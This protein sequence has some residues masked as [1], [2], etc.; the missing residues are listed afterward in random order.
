[1]ARYPVTMAQY[2]RFVEEGGVSRCHMTGASPWT[3]PNHPV[4]DVTWYDALA[5]CGG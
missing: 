4:V 1:M 3:L 2:R 5:F